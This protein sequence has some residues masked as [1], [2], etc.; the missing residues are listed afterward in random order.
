MYNAI[1]TISPHPAGPRL[2]D[3][4]RFETIKNTKERAL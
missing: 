4:S 3:N 1:F 2:N